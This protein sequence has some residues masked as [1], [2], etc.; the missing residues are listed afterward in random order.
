MLIDLSFYIE[1]CHLY[2][3]TP[4]FCHH[5]LSEEERCISPAANQQAPYR[6]PVPELRKGN[7][8]A[9]REEKWKMIYNM[10][11]AQVGHGMWQGGWGEEKKMH[12]YMWY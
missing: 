12:V 4:E 1:L 9:E 3:I 11:L 10:F 5:L 6:I 8:E 7:R 2:M